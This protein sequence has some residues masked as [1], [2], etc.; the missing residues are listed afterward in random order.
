MVRRREHFLWGGT[1]NGRSTS[2]PRQSLTGQTF[3][4]ILKSGCK[5]E[6]SKPRT[7]ERIVRLIAVFCILSWR[8]FWMTMM[9]RLAPDAS[10]Q[11]ALTTVEAR[12][13]D[14][15]IP[16]S[17]AKRQRNGTLSRYL[18]KIARLGGYNILHDPRIHRLA[19]RSCGV[20]LRD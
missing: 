3:H 16:E 15:L 4:K 1:G 7:A 17:K 13:L 19:I 10:P 2:A 18:T 20:A 11:V 6:A 12:L 14:T 5:A 8:I 9:N